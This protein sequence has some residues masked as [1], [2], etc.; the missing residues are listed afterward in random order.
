MRRVGMESGLA[1]GVVWKVDI[2]EVSGTGSIVC[3]MCEAVEVV[4][5]VVV[6]Q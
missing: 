2:W 5:D 3:M 6:W 4:G 1:R